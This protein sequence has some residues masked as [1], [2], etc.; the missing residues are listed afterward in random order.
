[1]CTLAVVWLDGT[2]SL[3]NT[4][5]LFHHIRFMTIYGMKIRL[6]DKQLT[7]L[8]KGERVNVSIMAEFVGLFHLLW[9]LK[10]EVSDLV[11]E[12][13]K[14]HLWYITEESV[15]TALP[16]EDLPSEERR[17]LG[18]ALFKIRRQDQFEPKQ[19]EFFDSQ[20]ETDFR[21]SIEQEN[22]CQDTLLT[23]DES[24]KL[25]PRDSKQ[26]VKAQQMGKF[27]EFE[28]AAKN[29]GILQKHFSNTL[30]L[31]LFYM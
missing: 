21:G 6:L 9:F 26:S 17:D 13:M 14:K 31:D 16:D 25:V 18:L 5:E 19:S 20:L 23:V 7:S 15:V 30:S 8:S 10:P 27:V 28:F 22:M 3:S 4:K 12:N 11:L 24:K 1:M 29:G 2:I